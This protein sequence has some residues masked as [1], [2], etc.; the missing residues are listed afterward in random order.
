MS[1]QEKVLVKY[2]FETSKYHVSAR[3]QSD[4]LEQTQ[5]LLWA[6]FEKQGKL[7]LHKQLEE[8]LS[9]GNL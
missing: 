6:K 9:K 7:L 2:G 3:N 1:K 8:V 5:L 4:K